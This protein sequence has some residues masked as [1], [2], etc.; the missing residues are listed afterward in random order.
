MVHYHLPIHKDYFGA[1][2]GI[3]HIFL[4]TPILANGVLRQL[5]TTQSPTS[6]EARVHFNLLELFWLV[7]S[8][9][10]KNISQL[11]LLFPIYGNIK[12]VPNHQP[13]LVS[14]HLPVCRAASQ[15]DI[16]TYFFSTY[17]PAAQQ[18]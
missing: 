11:G 10:L 16:A 1:Y 15:S 5:V 17:G 9:P 6:F 18:H 2:H 8:A 7:V 3:Y 4:D 14:G 12:N 13:V